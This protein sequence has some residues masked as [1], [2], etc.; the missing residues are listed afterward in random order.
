MATLDVDTLLSRFE[1]YTQFRRPT[2]D[3][4]QQGCRLYVVPVPLCGFPEK[5]ISECSRVVDFHLEE[6]GAGI[7]ITLEKSDGRKKKRDFDLEVVVSKESV[8]FDED[9]EMGYLTIVFFTDK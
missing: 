1:D 6:H 8:P 2:R 3:D 4:L 9:G 5:K 7:K